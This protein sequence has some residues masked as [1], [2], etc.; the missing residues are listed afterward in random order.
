MLLV[1]AA[2]S[3]PY[4]PTL[5]G[6][7]C[8]DDK[9]AVGGNP[10][11]ALPGVTLMDIFTHD[12]WGNDIL[13]RRPGGWT[14]DSWRPLVTLS[15]RAN[16][17]LGRLDTHGY[18]VTNLAIHALSCVLAY[19][20]YRT[21]LVETGAKAPRM[22]AFA[23]AL[24][25][26]L[27]PLHSETVANI[28]GRSDPMAATASFAA[29][30]VYVYGR[31]PAGTSSRLQSAC[32]WLAALVAVLIG[33]MCKE[34]ALV[35]PALLVGVDAAVRLQGLPAA[36]GEARRQGYSA[37]LSLLRGLLAVVPWLRS[38]AMLLAG[39]A[40]YYVRIVRFSNGYSLKAF[41]NELH[42][43]LAYIK[44]L[45]PRTRAIAFVQAWALS[46]TVLPLH[47]SHEHG[48][49]APV[50]ELSDVRNAVTV[51]VFSV[52]LALL[53]WAL[54]ALG[55][56]SL[57]I[58]GRGG[59]GRACR[60][61]LC[62]GW[63]TVSY[64]P[65]SHAFLFV[66]FVV[67]ERTLF[68]PSW[69]ACMLLTEGSAALAGWGDEAAAV[70]APSVETS[71]TRRGL[72]PARMRRGAKEAVEERPA[73]A[74]APTRA[75]FAAALYLLLATFFTIRT[76][77]R[78]YD[79]LSEEALLASNMNLYPTR[80]GMSVYGLGAIRLYAERWDEAEV[81]L[82][83]AAA[84]T[85]LAEPR[86]L[87]SQ[88]AWRARGD[89]E[90]AIAHLESIEHCS[91]PRKE[92]MQ[93][94]GLLLEATGRVRRDDAEAWERVERLILT[95]H[96]GHGYPAGHP[97]VGLLASNAACTRLLSDSERYGH[98]ELALELAMQGA[99]LPHSARFTA[100][101]NLVAIHAVAGRVP[102][103]LAALDEA[104]RVL[105]DVWAGHL[106]SGAAA[107]LHASARSVERGFDALRL[108]LAV[109]GPDMLRWRG[110]PPSVGEEARAR[111]AVLGMECATE[112]LYW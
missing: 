83:E 62:L 84:S 98:P 50:T 1:A 61:L 40:L 103:A 53:G 21:L 63:L 24:L 2:G 104:Q 34:T 105:A 58:D 33:V 93:N 73:V 48:A 43:P 17:L 87:L 71:S 88:L 4:I 22:S 85:S 5:R 28:T 110:G 106:A 51:I 14:H 60:V 90:S 9:V 3:L 78:G 72:S 82:R 101:R 94:L 29:L 30:A 13:R 47:L 77:T 11:V 45:L 86:I 74:P 20:A 23:A 67:A 46:L 38:S 109:H 96:A 80:N 26:A 64:A 81:L 111:L 41:A 54:W 65:S 15:F 52:L 19:V 68:L 39:A 37:S 108:T 56:R 18:H 95:G 25:F 36:T 6:E 49:H 27:H 107:A 8:Y 70:E 75:P 42:N 66:A 97:H 35:T 44:D 76:W 69:A 12:F 59:V 79:W 112:L 10:D 92:V 55:S 99:A 89:M 31:G 100:L 102:E 91:S 32:A 57:A 16:H 7:F